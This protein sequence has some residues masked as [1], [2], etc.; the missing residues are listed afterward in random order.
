MSGSRADWRPSASLE[1]LRRRAVMLA[2]ARSYFAT[3]GV[4][5]VD[6]P[7]VVGHAVTDINIASSSVDIA[8]A[9]HARHY[10]HTSPE[11]AMKRLLAAG[12]GDIYQ[13]CHVVRGAEQGVLHNREFTLIEWYRLG[14]SVRQ[15]MDEVATLLRLLLGPDLAGR[16]DCT[17]YATVMRDALGVDP[18]VASDADLAG[19]AARQGFDG[20]LLSRCGR[21]ELLDLLMGTRVGPTLGNDGLCFVHHYPASQAA[22][23][24]LDPQDARTALRFEVYCRGIE[25]ANGF[26]ELA[27]AAEQRARFEADRRE[28]QRRGLPQYA[29]D[30]RLLAALTHGLPACS[31]VAV[32]FDRVVM[33]AAGA[34]HIEQVLP[35][36]A[37]RA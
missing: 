37:D 26:E 16:V 27:D 7:L 20:N 15:L 24:R 30:E 1:N 28:R 5:E 9:V 29:P 12:S 2:T 6:T 3:H 22:L 32:G 19:C 8:G 13:I 11:Y 17:A 25:L 35:F 33:L 31:G 34:S 14:W 21:D 23:A 4:L 18:L 36:A 10:L